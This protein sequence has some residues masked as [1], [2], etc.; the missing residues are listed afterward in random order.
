[1][2]R[3][4]LEIALWML[5]MWVDMRPGRRC[6]A[7]RRDRPRPHGVP[8]KR[9]QTPHHMDRG[10][11]Q[12]GVHPIQST[13][14]PMAPMALVYVSSPLFFAPPLRYHAPALVPPL[15]SMA[16]T[17]ALRWYRTPVSGPV[18][19]HLPTVPMWVV[20]PDAIGKYHGLRI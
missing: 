18:M 9:L 19:A 10:C 7:P 11:F 2:P 12:A 16:P 8:P 13:P 20:Q 5:I 3:G 1:V 14:H 15:I 6:V 4:V 17:P